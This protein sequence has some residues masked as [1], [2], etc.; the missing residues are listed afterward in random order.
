MSLPGTDMLSP[1]N[2]LELE[3]RARKARLEFVSSSS[4]SSSSLPAYRVELE[5]L[6]KLELVIGRVR[7][8]SIR[9]SSRARLSYA[10]A[11]LGSFNSSTSYPL[12][13]PSPFFSSFLLIFPFLSSPSLFL[14]L[15]LLSSPSSPL[16]R[17]TPPLPFPQQIWP[18]PKVAI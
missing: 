13:P 17:H 7:V 9:G 2:E 16:S 15:L 18:Q 4:L 11:R 5:R 14:L 8:S 6:V 3:F 12:S 10:R 1:V